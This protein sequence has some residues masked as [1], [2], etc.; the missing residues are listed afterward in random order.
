MFFKIIFI[1]VLVKVTTENVQ[2]FKDLARGAAKWYA[3]LRFHVYDVSDR[4]PKSLDEAP[5]ENRTKYAATV[6][7]QNGLR[8]KFLSA[9]TKLLL[10]Y[11]ISVEA[12][13]RL[14]EGMLCVLEMYKQ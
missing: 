10:R 9:F 6:M 5:Y 11:R 1:P 13:K 8:A 12:L 2:L 7:N 14:N 3:E 4:L